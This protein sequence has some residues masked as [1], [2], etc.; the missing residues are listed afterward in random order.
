VPW[1]AVLGGT[2]AEI[3]ATERDVCAGRMPQH[4]FV[5]IGQQ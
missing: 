2:F 5:P 4:P 1:T 3:V